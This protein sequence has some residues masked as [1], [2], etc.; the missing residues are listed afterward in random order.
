MVKRFEIGASDNIDG[1]T[2]KA[3]FGSTAQ[4]CYDTNDQ[5]VQFGHTGW[6]CG[7]SHIPRKAAQLV[8]GGRGG[9]TRL[10]R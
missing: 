2:A 5:M 4:T 10:V 7:P 9:Q 8:V 1:V 3:S 6:I